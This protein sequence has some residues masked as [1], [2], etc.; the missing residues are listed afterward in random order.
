MGFLNNL[1]FLFKTYFFKSVELEVKDFESDGLI[2]DIGGGGEGVIGRL[3]GSQGVAI[4]LRKAELEETADGPIKVV[5][6]ARSLAFLDGSFQTATAFFSM[7]Y[8]QT[9]DDHQK[10]L[11]EAWRVLKPGGRLHLWEIDLSTL[12]KT[13]KEFYLVRLRY[14]AGDFQA[15][16]GYGMRWPAESRGKEYYRQLA[17]QAGFQHLSTESTKHLFYTV[18]FKP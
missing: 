5:M 8:M 18:F 10:V 17:G 12:P 15:S 13:S 16:T 3:K 2:L 14:R 11:S 6:D 1:K 7:M 4:D 9:R